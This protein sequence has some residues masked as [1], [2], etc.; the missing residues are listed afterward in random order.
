MTTTTVSVQV[1][2][3]GDIILSLDTMLIIKMQGV[4][5]VE[6]KDGFS[7]DKD[8][9]DDLLSTLQFMRGRMK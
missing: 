2:E 3:Y 9:V 6:S 1:A 4:D 8:E 5:D 7:L